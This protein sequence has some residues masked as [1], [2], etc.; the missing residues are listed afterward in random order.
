MKLEEIV[1]ELV[2][3]ILMQEEEINA[4]KKKISRINQYIEVYEEFIR[5]EDRNDY[6]DSS[7]GFY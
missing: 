4:L 5:K 3:L 6:Y 2:S 1:D 7:R